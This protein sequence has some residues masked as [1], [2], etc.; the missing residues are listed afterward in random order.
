MAGEILKSQASNGLWYLK[1]GD[2]PFHPLVFITSSRGTAAIGLAEVAEV[3]VVLQ[4]SAP[5]PGK[6]W[7]LGGFIWV[8]MGYTGFPIQ[9]QWV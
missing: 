9:S 6:P 8:K 5:R 1:T 7:K 4:M 2:I 3:V